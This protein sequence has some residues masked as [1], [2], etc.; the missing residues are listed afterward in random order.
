MAKS[1]RVRTDVRRGGDKDKNI[2]FELNQDFDLLEILSLS[3]TQQEVYTRMCADFGVVVGRVTTNGGF[4]I[5]NAKVSI[6]IPLDAEDE[7]NEV[8]KFLYP[9][10]EPFDV[11]DEGKRY[12]LLSSEKTFDCH[13]SVGTFPTLDNVLNK[14][15]VKYVYDKYYK[16]T[17]KTN[18]SGD[19]MIYG[20]PV[21]D[22]TIIMDVDVSDIGCFS[23]L[24][25]DFKVKGYSD[26]D[27]DGPRFKDD[28]AINSL[29][30]FIYDFI[31]TLI[32][33]AQPS[34]LSPIRN[35]FFLFG[36]GCCIG[37]NFST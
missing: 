29:P 17:V 33:S 22:Q 7:E 15:E 10:K 4:G 28:R 5:P 19:F 2:T 24:P 13:V 21:G 11:N 36:Y 35:L 9:F 37:G 30:Q 18:E 6:F 14:Q 20:A 3:L 27:F 16:L 1:F 31:R 23:L 25:E 26:T 8:I 32:E 34:I 12:N